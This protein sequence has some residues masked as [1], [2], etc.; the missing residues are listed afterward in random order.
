LEK[1]PDGLTICFHLVGKLK[2][3]G[4]VWMNTTSVEV[5]N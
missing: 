2:R 1:D 3:G 4:G 5:E